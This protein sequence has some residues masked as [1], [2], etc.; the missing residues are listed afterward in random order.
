M[1]LFDSN[2]ELE[3]NGVKMQVE[4]LNLPGYTAF[5]VSFSSSRLPIVVARATKDGGGKFW[6]SIPEGR[7]KEA[8]GIGKLIGQYHNSQTK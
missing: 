3:L 1:I 2:F 5:R 7:Q 8:E 4:G 6:T